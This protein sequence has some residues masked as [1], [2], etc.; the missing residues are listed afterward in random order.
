MDFLSPLLGVGLSA[1]VV[2]CKEA[3]GYGQQAQPV[4]LATSADGGTHWVTQGSSIPASSTSSPPV[5]EQVVAT[6]TKT[7]WVLDHGT[8]ML[9]ED[10]GTTWASQPLP[11]PV[12]QIAQVGT[13]I[14]ALVCSSSPGTGR[15]SPVLERTPVTG[16]AWEM[17]AVP[18]LEPSAS[19]THF[20]VATPDVVVLVVSPYH[21]TPGALVVTS[22]AG[23]HWNLQATPTGP[24]NL[25]SS[26]ADFAAASQSD[27]WLL[28]IGGAAAGSS[29]KALMHT[30]DGGQ[31]WVT[32]SAVTSL[33]D[34]LQPGSIILAEPADLAAGSPSRLW[35][36]AFNFLTDSSDGGATW[37]RV[38]GVFDE[39]GSLGSF[40]V[41]SSHIAWLL[42]PGDG[43]WA[44]TDGITWNA[45]GP[46]TSY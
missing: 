22:D 32:V 1:P 15:C 11:S 31:T 40:D 25:C 9:T 24:G 16:G 35:L 39:G 14:W 6:S 7:V 18:Q 44:T 5:I 42:A 26:D 38:H 21:N 30:L 45:L 12:V 41:L 28:C 34:R 33:T 8:V 29:T 10:G 2:P 27:W 36:A 46:V 37:T 19:Y 13:W 3:Q 43:L 4:L 23:Q 17:L 20:V